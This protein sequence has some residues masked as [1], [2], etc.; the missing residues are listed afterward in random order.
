MILLKTEDK[1][2]YEDILA[3]HLLEYIDD[4]RLFQLKIQSIYR[5]IQRYE[6]NR[7]LIEKNDEENDKIKPNRIDLIENDERDIFFGFLFKSLDKYGKEASILFSIADFGNEGKKYLS[8][9]TR[10]YSKIF[11]FHFI[12][13][14]I[15]DTIYKEEN[16]ILSRKISEEEIIKKQEEKIQSLEQTIT[17]L[18]NE[19]NEM[20][21]D[22]IQ[23]NLRM[24]NEIQ[25]NQQKQEKT[26]SQVQEQMKLMQDEI[27]NIK[28]S[29]ENELLEQKNHSDNETDQLKMTVKKL[30]EE[31][32]EIKKSAEQKIDEN[33]LNEM[34]QFLENKQGQIHDELTNIV[35]PIAFAYSKFKQPTFNC[36]D[37]QKQISFINSLMKTI[38]N[39]FIIKI[40]ELLTYLSSEVSKAN[41]QNMNSNYIFIISDNEKQNDY[42]NKVGISSFVTEILYE[43]NSLESSEISK[44]IDHF[45]EFYIEIQYPSSNYE[46]IYKEVI[47]MKQ[48]YHSKLKIAIFITGINETD[49][50]F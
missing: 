19:L 44:F 18:K 26:L 16:E 40:S 47:K 14:K 50:K 32:N 45:A 11:D 3:D 7:K 4:E 15:I 29:Y 49:D 5:I 2:T 48:K 27:S 24:T 37:G 6:E 41:K 30:T 43:N 17:E 23:S 34:K 39:E 42:V 9:L 35:Y 13:E 8:L 22:Q 1:G 38:N 36:L 20:K 12:D 10:D 21:N 31:I 28:K 33:K 25:S 46:Y